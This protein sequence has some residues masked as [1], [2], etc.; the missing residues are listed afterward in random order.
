MRVQHDQVLA[1]MLP[2][3]DLEAPVVQPNLPARM[4]GP[5]SLVVAGSAALLGTWVALSLILGSQALPDPSVVARLMWSDV[6]SGALPYHLSV[7]MARVGVATV[8]ALVCGGAIGVATGLSARGDLFL[9]PWLVTGLSAPRL[10]IIV[11]AYLLVGLNEVAVAVATALIVAP[12]V[13]VAMREGIRALDWALID[14]ARVFSVPTL[15]SWR[16]VV[17]PQL[18]PYAAGSARNALSLSLKMILFAELMG[19]SSGVGYQIAFYFQMFN[20]G[21]ILA[22]GAGT[23]LVAAVMELAMRELERRVYRWRSRRS[24]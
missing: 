11:V 9:A 10:V 21:Q 20:M 5:P 2:S 4:I 13:A 15:R 3:A 18:L 24:A 19:R 17:L 1:R 8:L 16:Q 23:V 12:S 22:Y 14:M 7:T 6:Q